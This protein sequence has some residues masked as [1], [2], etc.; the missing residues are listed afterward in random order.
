MLLK[1]NFL[2]DFVVDVGKEVLSFEVKFQKLEKVRVTRS[3]RSFL[4]SYKPNKG[5]VVHLGERIEEVI[6]GVQ[7]IALPFYELFTANYDELFV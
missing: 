2:V 6:E 4:Q 5:F 7:M 3:L 1:T